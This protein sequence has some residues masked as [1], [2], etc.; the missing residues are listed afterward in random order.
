MSQVLGFVPDADPT[1]PGVI[2]DC[3]LLLPYDLGMRACP[4]AVGVGLPALE[5][6]SRGVFV[7]VDL[8]GTRRL[9]AGTLTAL[10]QAGSSAWADVSAEPYSLGADDRWSLAQFGNSVLAATPSYSIQRLTA[11]AFAE[12]ADA[13][14]AR[15]LV[16]VKSF[17]M[18]FGTNDTVFGDSPDRWWCCANLNETDWVPNIATQCTTGRL[19][20]S[21]GRFTAAAR[22]GDDVVTYKRNAMWLGRY[23]GSPSVWD[24]IPI[25]SDIGCVG[26]EA[27]CDTGTGHIFVGIDDIYLFDGNRPQSIATGKCRDWYVA[28]RDPKN[29]YKTRILWDRQNSLAWIFFVSINGNGHIDCGLVYHTRTG[30]WGRANFRA[31]S[32]VVYA[33]PSITYDDGA[34]SIPTAYDDGP[35][36][37]FDSPFWTEGQELIAIVDDTHTL[38]TLSGIPADSSF[39]TGDYGDEMSYTMCNS[40]KIRYKVAPDDATATGYVKDDGGRVSVQASSAIRD[41]SAFDLRQTGR[42]HR[43]RVDQTGPAEVLAIRPA[44]QEAGQR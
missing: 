36:I 6:E 11:G 17:V 2:V 37:P 13:P 16:S 34:L 20:E 25:A 41:D 38:K 5:E 32:V 23:V 7:G 9:I 22:F 26:Q 43:F 30:R 24:F 15:I 14:K 33:S 28:N 42:W 39:T 18:A 21:G 4:T 19:V 3:E 10:Y 29:A 8:L 12:I 27:V 31:E 1:P 40:L 35:Q 44:M